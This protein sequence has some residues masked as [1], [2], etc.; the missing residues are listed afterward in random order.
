MYQLKGHNEFH[1]DSC[2]KCGHAPYPHGVPCLGC[3]QVGETRRTLY[4]GRSIAGMVQ[5]GLWVVA[6]FVVCY[7]LFG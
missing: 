3:G 6:L 7:F 4:S 2:P 5:A 1:P